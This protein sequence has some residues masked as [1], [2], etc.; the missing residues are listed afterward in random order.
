MGRMFASVM[1]ATGGNQGDRV[2]GGGTIARSQS[3]LGS[4]V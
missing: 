3:G 1:L 2:L 4:V